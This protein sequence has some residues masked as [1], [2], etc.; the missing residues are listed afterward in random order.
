MIEKWILALFQIR[1]SLKVNY[2]HT[3]IIIY[4]RQIFGKYKSISNDF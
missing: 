3:Y 2:T 1:F 4:I